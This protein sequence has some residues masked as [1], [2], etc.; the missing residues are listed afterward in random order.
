MPYFS[1]YSFVCKIKHSDFKNGLERSQDR[2]KV[3]HI[4]DIYNY[5]TKSVVGKP[6]GCVDID[7]GCENI[8][9]FVDIGGFVYQ[10]VRI[11]DTEKSFC[12]SQPLTGKKIYQN[13]TWQFSSKTDL[14]LQK[15]EIKVYKFFRFRLYFK[16]LQCKFT[17]SPKMAIY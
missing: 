6:F 16:H 11:R 13:K 7:T 4:A 9:I 8:P 3:G 15:C 17:V 2:H 1:E 5:T 14:K 12:S 10:T